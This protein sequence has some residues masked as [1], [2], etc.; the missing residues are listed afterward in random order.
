MQGIFFTPQDPS[1]AL[2]G[3]YSVS[4]GN[5]STPLLNFDST[6]AATQ[7]S[8][9]ASLQSALDALGYNPTVTFVPVG[10]AAN[11]VYVLVIQ[12]QG[13]DLAHGTPLFQ[14]TTSMSASAAVEALDSSAFSGSSVQIIKESSDA[15]RVND[16]EPLFNP[17]TMVRPPVYNQLN[18]QVA[19]DADGDFV[20][21]WQSYTPYS[22][23]PGSGYDI[24]ARR[25][26]PAGYAATPSFISD[27]RPTGTSDTTYVPVP[28]E[29]VVPAGDQ[30]QVNTT[31]ANSQ[32]EPSVAMDMNGNFTIA[33]QS[34]GKDLSFSNNIMA[35]HFDRDGNRLGNEFTVNGLDNTTVNF[36]PDVGMAA[37]GT[38]AISWT[39]TD[40][41]NYVL[42]TSY[43]SNVVAK[44]YNAQGT[45]LLGDFGVGGGGFSTVA[46]DSND[47]FVVSWDMATEHDNITGGGFALGDVY[48][49]EYELYST[50]G[51]VT[52]SVIRPYFRVGG[53]PGSHADELLALR[54]NERPGGHG[55]QR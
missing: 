18:S 39:N 51:V 14:C 17:Q 37:D 19:M 44:V 25:F 42:D 45:V 16:P 43:D 6:S 41:P 3:Q 7:T 4:T 48:A 5:G 22:V 24:Y 40:D 32:T 38:F 34:E 53:K 30:F 49:Q 52:G 23:N 9:A 46:F 15:F 11:P 1:T 36:A 55:R 12:W 2:T 20:I 27:M 47:D 29:C 50:P 28:I 33:W 8:T 54:P 13:T 21:T 31:T 35:Q 26:S 10:T